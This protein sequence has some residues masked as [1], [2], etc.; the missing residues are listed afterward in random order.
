MGMSLALDIAV[1]DGSEGCRQL[2]TARDLAWGQEPATYRQA[3]KWTAELGTLA[4]FYDKVQNLS[5]VAKSEIFQGDRYAESLALRGEA[6]WRTLNLLRG[7]EDWG[8]KWERSW[9]WRDKHL[10]GGVD[11]DGSVLAQAFSDF[12]IAARHLSYTFKG[13]TGRTVDQTLNAKTSVLSAIMN[14]DIA[15]ACYDAAFWAPSPGR[16][17]QVRDRHDRFDD[18]VKVWRTR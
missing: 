14:S 13:F 18:H 16:V 3:F 9:L 2:I 12:Q 7:Q 5:S 4:D 1:S 8:A 10:S 11:L 6:G 15:H 17:S